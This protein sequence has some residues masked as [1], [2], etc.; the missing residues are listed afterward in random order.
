MPS[1]EL[2]KKTSVAFDNRTLKTVRKQADWL[3]LSLSAFLRLVAA[4]F[5]ASA[6]RV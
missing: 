4:K 2:Q 1:K 5:E 6:I 3:N